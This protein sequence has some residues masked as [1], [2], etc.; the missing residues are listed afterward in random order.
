MKYCRQQK[1]EA[2]SLSLRTTDL[3]LLITRNRGTRTC[4]NRSDGKRMIYRQRPQASSYLSG[5]KA[6]RDAASRLFGSYTQGYF[7]IR[8]RACC[9]SVAPSLAR[10]APRSTARSHC[11]KGK[12]GNL[13]SV[14]E[15]LVHLG[16][17][18]RDAEVDCPV[19]D[20]DDE[21][22]N[23]IGVDLRISA[24]NPSRWAGNGKSINT[25]C[26]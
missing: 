20:L 10:P 5:T 26:S 23:D 8:P 22:A 12:R 19:A 15:E 3:S 6:K 2:G 16:H 11:Y 14:G 9:G 25:P 13:Q 21:P 1:P 4:R 17:L 24:G 7:K 18:G